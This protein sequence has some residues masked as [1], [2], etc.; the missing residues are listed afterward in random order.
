[1][2]TNN[3]KD[4]W[5]NAGFESP[6]VHEAW[7]TERGLVEGGVGAPAA[8]S[9]FSQWV[10][11][12]ERVAAWLRLPHSRSLECSSHRH[13]SCCTVVVWVGGC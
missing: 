13:H 9:V 3:R 12:K 10:R 4:T 7:T 2:G 8:R 5:E 1:M 6:P 11:D